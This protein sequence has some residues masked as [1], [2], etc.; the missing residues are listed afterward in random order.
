M[1]S[2]SAASVVAPNCAIA[3]E[4]TGSRSVIAG[5]F[6]SSFEE[7][8]RGA[9]GWLRRLAR[10]INHPAACRRH[11]SLAG[12]DFFSSSA[13]LRLRLARELRERGLVGDRE[14]GEDL[15]VDVDR[16]LLQAVHERGVREAVLAHGGVDARDP[17]RTE[18]ALSLA[19]VA[20]GVLPR[21][22]HR[23]LGDGEDVAAPAA[24]ALG[25]VEDLL[26]LGLRGDA[27]FYSGHGVSLRVGQH[28]AHALLVGGMDV[29]RAAQVAL[30]LGRLLGED[31]ALVRLGALDAAAGPDLQALGG[32]AFGL[33]LGHCLTPSWMATGGSGGA[34]E[35]SAPLVMKPP[36]QCEATGFVSFGSFFTSS[37]LTGFIS[38]LPFFGASTMISC[39]P[40]IFG[41]CST[42]AYGSRSFL[43][44]SI[45]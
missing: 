25:L 37:F 34:L 8:W 21:L 20:V 30:V 38:F 19:A 28:R 5:S 39:R 23:F 6:P 7:G 3:S 43:T 27:A 32:A 36:S 2:S 44:R 10:F 22:H 9:P 45:R 13:E 35:T 31:V 11:P 33:H 1:R 26:V 24:E 17:Q 42:V 4:T 12:G 15:A 16:G 41:N 14:V 18:L 40:S 29:L